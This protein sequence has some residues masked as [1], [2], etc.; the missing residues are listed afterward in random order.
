MRKGMKNLAALMGIVAMAGAPAAHA[1]QASMGQIQ[2]E[3]KITANR[4]AVQSERRQMHSN[5]NP[6]KA[7]H[8]IMGNQRQNRKHWRQCPWSRPAK[9]RK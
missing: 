5:K 7:T 4:P 9:N 6:F 8:W 1:A 2:H 3:Y